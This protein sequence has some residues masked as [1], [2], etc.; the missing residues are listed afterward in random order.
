MSYVTRFVRA[1]LAEERDLL[2]PKTIVVSGGHPAPEILN[3]I[4]A[5]HRGTCSDG[6]SKDVSGTDWRGVEDPEVREHEMGHAT[7][8]QKRRLAQVEAMLDLLDALWT[9][10]TQ[11]TLIALTLAQPWRDHEEFNP[12]WVATT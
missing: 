5:D 6:W 10:R 11:R 9:T 4:G 2:R 8:D 3:C 1:R 12:G 7:A